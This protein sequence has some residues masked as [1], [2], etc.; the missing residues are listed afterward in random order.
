MGHGDLLVTHNLSEGKP[1]NLGSNLCG[2]VR[3]ASGFVLTGNS[4]LILYGKG[5]RPTC[6][7]S[8]KGRKA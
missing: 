8:A 4:S 2:S 1:T 7:T 6:A 5:C 3:R